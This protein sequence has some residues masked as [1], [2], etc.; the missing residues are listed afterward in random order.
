MKTPSIALTLSLIFP[1]GFTLYRVFSYKYLEDNTFS[2][3]SSYIVWTML[4]YTLIDIFFIGLAIYLNSKQKYYENLIMCGTLFV[5]F[6]LS[7]IINSANSF[8]FIWLK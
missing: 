5:A 7:L 4:S 3:P 1:I 2:H 6:I 8:I